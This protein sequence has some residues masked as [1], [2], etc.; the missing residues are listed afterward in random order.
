METGSR[1]VYHRQHDFYKD[2]NLLPEGPSRSKRPHVTHQV[3]QQ[4]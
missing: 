1:Y 2:R 4:A 3:R